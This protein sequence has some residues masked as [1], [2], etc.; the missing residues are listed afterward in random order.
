MRPKVE[1]FHVDI[2]MCIDNTNSMRSL[3]NLVK[4]NALS[5]PADLTACCAKKSK[6]LEDFRLRVISFGDLEEISITKSDFMEIPR[7]SRKFKDFVSGIKMSFGGDNPEDGLEA[8]AMAINSDWQEGS[9]RCRHIIIVYTDAT[10]HSLGTRKHYVYYPV[11]PM[12]A[13]FEELSRWWNRLDGKAS[14]LILFA[15]DEDY[16]SI[17]KDE[18]PH[19]YLK[20]LEDVLSS[21]SGY[22][23]ILEA[24]SNSL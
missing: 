22:D 23:Q 20:P 7:E 12:P 9:T 2:V 10:A 6:K 1:N 13:D 21:S 5:F 3:I 24:I 11:D 8:L 19:V 18:W 17:M 14:R 15:P 16:W 4:Q